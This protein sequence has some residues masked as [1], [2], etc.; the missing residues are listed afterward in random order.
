MRNR[1]YTGSEF[2]TLEKQCLS[3][4]RNTT[5]KTS[6]NYFFLQTFRTQSFHIAH[7]KKLA[8]HWDLS[9]IGIFGCGS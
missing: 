4:V 8:E 7:R 3:Y 5:G 1:G 2:E 6:I 9:N